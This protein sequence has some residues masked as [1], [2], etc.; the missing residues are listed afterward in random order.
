MA[1]RLTFLSMEEVRQLPLGI[2]VSHSQFILETNRQHYG[3]DEIFT[4]IC[5]NILE[6]MIVHGNKERAIRFRD[7]IEASYPDEGQIKEL[8]EKAKDPEYRIEVKI[9]YDETTW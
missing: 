6:V 1:E 4:D 5:H 7:Y 2:I 8:E 9:P 3:K